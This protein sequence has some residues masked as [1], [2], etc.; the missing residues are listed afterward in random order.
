MTYNISWAAAS[1]QTSRCTERKHVKMCLDRYESPCPINGKRCQSCSPSYA[2]GG[3]GTEYFKH[4]TGLSQ[5][6][7]HAIGY[8]KKNDG[9]WF[10]IGG[11]QEI[12]SE[13]YLIKI[14]NE[15]RSQSGIPYECV[16]IAVPHKSRSHSAVCS[17][18]YNTD[19]FGSIRNGDVIDLGGVNLDT[20]KDL[21]P[22]HAAY[23]KRAKLLFINA[24]F[25][26]R[27]RD[28][29]VRKI[30]RFVRDTVPKY[31]LTRADIAH[32]M[33]VGDTNSTNDNDIDL[34]LCGNDIDL[35]LPGKA[36][37]RSLH[38]FN[39]KTGEVFN[40]KKARSG[41]YIFRSDSI[42][43][44]ELSMPNPPTEYASDHH[45]VFA[46]CSIPVVSQQAQQ[47]AASQWHS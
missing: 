5:P 31:N 1:G 3:K 35:K 40:G 28:S 39:S 33:F 8:M 7:I 11:L 19:K 17:I 10:D 29:A 9:Q 43:M 25:P 26:Q 20:G 15:L 45:P 27:A 30:Q 6:T 46:T 18:I 16:T 21:R 4:G 32:V 38:H 44:S 47:Q 34:K 37:P 42:K 41:D 12:L 36:R 2:V 14:M 23:F 13:E 24:H 22:G